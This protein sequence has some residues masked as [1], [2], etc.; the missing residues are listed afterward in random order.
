MVAMNWLSREETVAL[1]W[2]L[3]HF[4]WQGTALALA[5]AVVDRI[6]RRTSAPSRY[7]VALGA[8]A[9]MP[10]VVVATF[11]I[12]MRTVSST[13]AITHRQAEINQLYLDA[14]PTPIARNLTLV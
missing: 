1:G 7:L 14:A 6:T 2:T 13:N 4:L 10:L 8:L 5:Y 11:A 12:E 3:L 9:L